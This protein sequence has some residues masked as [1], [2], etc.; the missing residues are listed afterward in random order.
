MT[1]PT[2]STAAS[3][4]MIHPELPDDRGAEWLARFGQWDRVFFPNVLGLELIEVR[5]DCARMR[6]PHRPEFD[7]PAG[8]TH[9]GAIASLIDTAVVPAVA[10]HTHTSR[11]Y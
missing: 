4:A 7:Q 3:R 5:E 10:S 8:V 2:E 1:D 11:S 9:G 6:L